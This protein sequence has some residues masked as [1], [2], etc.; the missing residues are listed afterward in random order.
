MK[1]T[2][3]PNVGLPVVIQKVTD[4]ARQVD[5]RARSERGITFVGPQASLP[6][7][8]VNRL[9]VWMVVHRPTPTRDYANKLGHV[10]AVLFPVDQNFEAAPREGGR[11]WDMLD[12]RALRR[13]RARQFRQGK[14]Y[15][16]IRIFRTDKAYD[17]QGIF[18]R[19]QNLINGARRYGDGGSRS[20]RVSEFVHAAGP[21]SPHDIEYFFS[22]WIP[23]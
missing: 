23:S 15:L 17:F 9:F 7:E 5:A 10:P 8:D 4:T 21:E 19:V 11:S 20:Q 14:V 22:E 3:Y 1:H 16:R 6:F 2:E 13:G 12:G 18:L